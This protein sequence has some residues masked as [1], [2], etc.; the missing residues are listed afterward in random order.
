[1]E[2]S[3]DLCV[4]VRPTHFESNRPAPMDDRK[5]AMDEWT[6]TDTKA[7]WTGWAQTALPIGDA[8]ADRR[9]AS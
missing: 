8:P 6:A 4:C 7:P 5:K 9:P 2:G 1:M 3:R